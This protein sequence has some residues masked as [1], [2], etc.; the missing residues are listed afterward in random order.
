[1][2]DTLNWLNLSPHRSRKPA[3]FNEHR[4]QGEPLYLFNLT[5]KVLRRLIRMRTECGT[6]FLCWTIPK[7]S[8]SVFPYKYKALCLEV[9]CIFCGVCIQ[10]CVCLWVCVCVLLCANGE[11]TCFPKRAQSQTWCLLEK[12]TEEGREYNRQREDKTKT[13][14]MSQESEKT[15]D[16]I[17][18]HDEIGC[19]ITTWE[20]TEVG[21]DRHQWDKGKLSYRKKKRWQ[22]NWGRNQR[23]KKKR[24]RG[25]R[26]WV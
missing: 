11:H 9:N 5:E 25:R 15:K 26:K 14:R 20:Q 24:T 3:H 22:R 17:W 7:L 10:V 4:S 12:M 13:D 1:M 18:D 6:T 19:Y 16:R 8:S 21:Q 2:E 23:G